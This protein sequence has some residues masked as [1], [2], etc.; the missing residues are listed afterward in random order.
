MNPI[1]WGSGKAELVLSQ[2]HPFVCIEI[3]DINYVAI[4]HQQSVH[5]AIGD[6]CGNDQNIDVL[7]M[8]PP[9]ICLDEDNV[10]ELLLCVLGW[11]FLSHK[12]MYLDSFFRVPVA[13]TATFFSYMWSTNYG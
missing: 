10:F 12:H 3:D 8:H 2:S 9:S 13:S 4:I 11:L 7:M 6:S 5:I 1:Q